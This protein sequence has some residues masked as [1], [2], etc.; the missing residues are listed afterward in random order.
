MDLIERFDPFDHFEPF[1]PL[2]LFKTVVPLLSFLFSELASPAMSITSWL[3]VW[4]FE[5]Q[6]FTNG[7]Y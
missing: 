7:R 4:W 1:D 6:A 3:V 2:A 5:Y